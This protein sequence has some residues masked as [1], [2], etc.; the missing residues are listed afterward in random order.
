MQDSSGGTK[1]DQLWFTLR[2]TFM[3]MVSLTVT[4][5]RYRLYQL[6]ID[7]TLPIKLNP[8]RILNTSDKKALTFDELCTISVIY[9][10]LNEC[11]TFLLS[12]FCFLV[13]M[14]SCIST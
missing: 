12:A 4:R 11:I 3:A 14:N 8:R 13:P 2:R 9:R 7:S 6:R 10:C 5:R 1:S